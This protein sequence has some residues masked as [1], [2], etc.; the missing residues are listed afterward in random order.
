MH[1]SKVLASGIE[2]AESVSAINNNLDVAKQAL[3]V[4]DAVEAFKPFV[5][6]IGMVTILAEDIFKVSSLQLDDL[7]SAAFPSSAAETGLF[8]SKSI[9]TYKSPRQDKD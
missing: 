3:G 5:P 1:T 2:I 8:P 4:I 7:N 6:F 9:D